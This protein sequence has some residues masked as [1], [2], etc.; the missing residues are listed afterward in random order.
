[1]T[2]FQAK[3]FSGSKRLLEVADKIEEIKTICVREQYF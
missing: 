3:L 2:D 1:K